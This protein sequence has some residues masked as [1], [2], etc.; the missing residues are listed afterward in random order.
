MIIEWKGKLGYGD[1]VSPICYAQNKSDILGEKVTLNF[2]WGDPNPLVQ[3]NKQRAIK[4]V[5]LLDLKDVEINHLDEPLS[6][7]HTN[8]DVKPCDESVKY[9]NVFFPELRK[10]DPHNI[11]VCTPLM[12]QQQLVEYNPG[13]AWK[14]GLTHDEW[15]EIYYSSFY[16]THVD[17]NTPFEEL[18]EILKDCRY[19]IGYHGSVSWM[20]RLFGIPMTIFSHDHKFTQ[21]AFPWSI[22]NPTFT[23]G[24]VLE[25]IIKYDQV[26]S[27]RN[28]YIERLRRV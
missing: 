10:K 22:N 7:N 13:K 26:V 21:W 1:I 11:V 16:P 17:Y 14:D 5:N 8:Y 23:E 25:S 18:I 12:N 4:L 28:E 20:A 27:E 9:H 24:D 2:Y 3:Q 15:T 19:F 6:Y